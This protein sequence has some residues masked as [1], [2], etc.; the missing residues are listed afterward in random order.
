MTRH[1]IP[2]RAPAMA[3]LSL[4]AFLAVW[5]LVKAVVPADGVSIAGVRVL[6]RTTNGALPHV[7]TVFT[8]FG[9]PEVAVPGSRTVLAGVLSA[10]WFSFRLALVGLIVGT[11]VGVLLAVLMQRF[12]FAER[13]LTPYVI[14]SQT[15][16]L[17][18]L[19]PLV[20]GWS[21]KIAIA[22]QPWTTTTS[23]IA[24]SA[25]LAFF[26][27]T[28]GMLRGLHAPSRQAVE[29]MHCYDAGW[30][31]TLLRLRLPVAIGYLLP[32]LRL[33]AAAA[34]VGGIVAEIS[35]A[36]SGGVGRLIVE[37]AQQSTGNAGKLF[38]AVIGAAA[39]GLLMTVLVMLLSLALKRFRGN[40]R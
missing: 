27:V 17:V 13:A 11:V 36:T 6:P 1:R 29:L 39:V 16:P 14:A 23:V 5:E 34:V 30:L 19:A 9:D 25:Y 21:G 2:L 12:I 15:V 40:T 22:G 28:L 33:A 32:A 37:Y 10:G 20:N 3:V 4:V 7:W 24:I 26:P 31:P 8:T 18:A 38:C 35:T